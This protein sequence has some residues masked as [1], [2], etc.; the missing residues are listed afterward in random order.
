[1]IGLKAEPVLRDLGT[2]GDI[3]KTMHRDFTEHGQDRDIAHDVMDSPVA[4]AEHRPAT[5]PP[6]HAA[7]PGTRRRR[8]QAGGR[9]RDAL[10]AGCGRRVGCR[11]LPPAPHPEL[12]PV[13]H[14][15]QRPGFARVPWTPA[16]DRYLGRHV[17]GVAK[18]SGRSSGV[19]DVSAGWR[20]ERA[21]RKGR[22][23][24]R[25]RQSSC[26]ACQSLVDRCRRHRAGRPELDHGCAIPG[27]RR[28][29]RRAARSGASSRSRWK[30]RRSTPSRGTSN[31]FSAWRTSRTRWFRPQA[32]SRRASVTAPARPS[33]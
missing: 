28:G 23:V 12:R 29:N 13:C 27:N 16:L 2:R 4:R 8:R 30:R 3:I 32:I 15:R 5:Q 17:A 25:G 26:P 21:F 1:M 20:S 24:Q 22:S 6:R 7:A 33:R 9:D 11:H 31:R 19:S 10:H 18:D 14:D